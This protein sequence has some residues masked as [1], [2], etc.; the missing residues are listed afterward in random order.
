MNIDPRQVESL[1][2]TALEA[3][4]AD[5]DL[6]RLKAS[7]ERRIAVAGAPRN[8]ADA[9]QPRRGGLRPL[10][11]IAA[12]ACVL[13]LASVGG[14]VLLSPTPATAESLVRSAHSAIVHEADRCYEVTFDVPSTWTRL[15]PLLKASKRTLVWTRGDRFRVEMDRG[16][17][18]LVWGQDE[19][20]RTWGVI[21]PRLGVTYDHKELPPAFDQAFSYLNIDVERLTEL[22]LSQYVLTREPVG[23]DRCA[24][25]VAKVRPG[26]RLTGKGPAQFNHVRLEIDEPTGT[27][28]RMELRRINRGE[29]I[30]YFN[31]TL[32]DEAACSD[33]S[34]RLR[35]NLEPG[36]RV[37]GKAQRAQR[38]A[39]MLDMFLP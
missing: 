9:R 19:K 4:A 20:Q 28:R 3:E 25:V 32:I 22:L 26:T 34:Y 6:D 30:A 10:R 5:V 12:A 31:F 23:V 15:A 1:V 27:I 7:L 21:D 18:T 13:L 11:W 2:R 33:D 39:L 17:E 8:P 16:A 36:A 35:G 24:V 38:S 14:Y 29:L 37:L